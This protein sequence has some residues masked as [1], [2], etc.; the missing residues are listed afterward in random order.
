MPPRTGRCST[1]CCSCEPFTKSREPSVA[2][3]VGKLWQTVRGW[4]AEQAQHVTVR[5]VPDDGAQPVFPNAG[6][7]RLWLAEGFL[8]QQRSWGANQFPALH[9]GVRLSF[10]GA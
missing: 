3:T 10:A 6:Y 2:D 5:F 1:S 9:G 7:T 4:F 8:A